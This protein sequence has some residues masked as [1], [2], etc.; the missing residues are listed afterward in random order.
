MRSWFYRL[1]WWPWWAPKREGRLLPEPL[2]V[3]SDSLWQE[4]VKQKETIQ[5][6]DVLI[7]WMDSDDCI[8][9]LYRSRKK[10]PYR[11]TRDSL[12]DIFHKHLHGDD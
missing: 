8:F 11:L 10:I 3:L 7:I 6:Q 12:L 2:A 1:R 5:N 4:P 9:V